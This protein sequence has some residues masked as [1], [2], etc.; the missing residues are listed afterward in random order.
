M[1]VKRLIDGFLNA[2]Q[3]NWLIFPALYMTHVNV[4]ATRR[5]CVNLFPFRL[6]FTCQI[7]FGKFCCFKDFNALGK[8]DLMKLKMLSDDFCLLLNKF[9]FHFVIFMAIEQLFCYL[10]MIC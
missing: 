3:H 7:S 6:T 10:E 1:D 5:G 4:K 9:E 2:C 8:D